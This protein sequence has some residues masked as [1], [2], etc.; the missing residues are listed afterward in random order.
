LESLILPDV[1]VVNE[2]SRLLINR[3][4]K[5]VQEGPPEVGFLSV[6]SN[7]PWLP[8]KRH[9]IDSLRQYFSIN[10]MTALGLPTNEVLYIDR[11]ERMHF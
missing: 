8:E 10:S 7:N 6:I 1:L 5:G 2:F 9:E 4:A 11:A 3:V